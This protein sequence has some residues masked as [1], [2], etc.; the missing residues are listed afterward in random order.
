MPSIAKLV[1]DGERSPRKQQMQ[2]R[3]AAS[4]GQQ[5]KSAH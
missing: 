1:R 3:S 5:E 2:K 4:R